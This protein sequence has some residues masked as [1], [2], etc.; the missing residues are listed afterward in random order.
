MT[1]R[2]LPQAEWPR[3]VGTEAADVWP[4]LNPMKSHVVVVEEDGQIIACHVLMHVLHAE[5]LWVHPDHRHPR[6]SRLLWN[7]V[8]LQAQKLGATTLA[9]AANDDRVK[10]LLAYVGATKLEGEHYVIPLEGPCL[11]Q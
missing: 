6:V 8:Q 4:H 2:I 5:C 1:T 10:R 11:P 9:T 7:E 3:L